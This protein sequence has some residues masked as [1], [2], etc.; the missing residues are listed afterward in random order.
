VRDLGQRVDRCRD[1]FEAIDRHR[2]RHQ[3]ESAAEAVDAVHRADA[4]NV[5]TLFHGGE[6]REQFRFVD[7]E[8]G[9]N[10]RER[11]GHERQILLYA[12]E[13]EAVEIVERGA[14]CFMPHDCRPR[15]GP[16]A[17]RSAL[18]TA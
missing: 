18:R 5:T 4:R 6:P 11:L 3:R 2:H 7:A 13:D 16:P 17:P 12:I 8:L 14:R 10:G 15:R 9:G 1:F